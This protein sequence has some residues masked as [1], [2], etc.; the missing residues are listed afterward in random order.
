MEGFR[1]NDAVQRVRVDLIRNQ[2]SG[3]FVE[4]DPG[5]SICDPSMSQRSVFSGGSQRRGEESV[6]SEGE[7]GDV[8]PWRW[9]CMV[10]LASGGQS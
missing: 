10:S 1:S 9:R 4:N 6:Q 7:F 8:A 5:A 2:M 3:P